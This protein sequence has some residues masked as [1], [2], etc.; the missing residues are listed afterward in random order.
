[1][2]EHRKIK[3]EIE[4]S[5]DRMRKLGLLDQLSEIRSFK[6]SLKRMDLE[7]LTKTRNQFRTALDRG[8]HIK[9]RQEN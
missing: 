1:M 7:N 6:Q 9:I 3:R 2:K 5:I 4:R 8:D